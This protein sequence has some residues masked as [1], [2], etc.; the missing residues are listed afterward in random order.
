MEGIAIVV[1]Y[2]F[3]FLF[4]KRFRVHKRWVRTWKMHGL[5]RLN[6]IE[7]SGFIEYS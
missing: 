1:V 2:N 5:R 4:S 6:M 7:N 3:P